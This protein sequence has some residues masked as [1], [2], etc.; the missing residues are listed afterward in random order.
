[1]EKATS[2]FDKKKKL[3]ASAKKSRQQ[4]RK[5]KAKQVYSVADNLDNVVSVAPMMKK[6][7]QTATQLFLKQSEQSAVDNEAR[8]NDMMNANNE[9]SDQLAKARDVALKGA[10]EAAE[11]N[12]EASRDLLTQQINQ[13]ALQSSLDINNAGNESA[14]NRKNALDAAKKA[15]DDA[16]K[17]LQNDALKQARNAVNAAAKL[18]QRAD[19]EAKAMANAAAAESARKMQEAEAKRVADLQAALQAHQQ[20]ARDAGAAFMQL[21]AAD[22][23]KMAAAASN[24]ANINYTAL[25]LAT[26]PLSV[27]LYMCNNVFVYPY[28]GYKCHE[29]VSPC[30]YVFENGALTQICNYG[31]SRTVCDMTPPAN[32]VPRHGTGDAYA[33]NFL[34]LE[35]IPIYFV[36][37]INSKPNLKDLN[38]ASFAELAKYVARPYL[39]TVSFKISQVWTKRLGKII[40]TGLNVC[41]DTRPFLRALRDVITEALGKFKNEVQTDASVQ[42]IIKTGA[43]D[44]GIPKL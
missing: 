11:A 43:W 38:L 41:L 26:P 10:A 6:S 18:Q 34:F 12:L 8:L 27:C 13:A 30:G 3:K 16:A 20:I 36:H 14:K 25:N 35:N 15:A 19:E 17:E 4:K 21:L 7:Q 1:M 33:D 2:A 5:F 28:A 44:S 37:W 29:D 39:D 24:L 23:A 31:S 22:A 32:S 9:R 40:T 42:A